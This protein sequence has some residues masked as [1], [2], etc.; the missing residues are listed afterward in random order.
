MD[1]EIKNTLFRFVNMKAPELC[2][3]IESKPN[4]ITQKQNDEGYFNEIIDEIIE[5]NFKELFEKYAQNSRFLFED[6]IRNALYLSVPEEKFE[7]FVKGYL[8]KSSDEY[9]NEVESDNKKIDE[10]ISYLDNSNKQ[11]EKYENKLD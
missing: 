6:A 1:T 2:S 11:R 4:F 10:I 3:E 7:L 5:I 9:E 8:K